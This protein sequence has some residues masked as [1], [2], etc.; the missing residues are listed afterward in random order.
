MAKSASRA[1]ALVPFSMSAP[2]PI[3]IRQ[4]KVQKAKKHRH[5]GGGGG[6][7]LMNK[8]RVGIIIGGGVL[9]FIEKQFAAQ[10]P[11][12]PVLGTTG[13]I[14]LAAYFLSDNGRNKLADEVCT[15]ALTVALWQLGN[16]GSI[17]GEEDPY[18]TGGY[19]AGA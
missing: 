16:T 4:T 5:H 2:K 7:G 19:V 15:A 11:K 6:S 14:G 10:I 12:I 13:T 8:R 17:V 9:G 3:I 18:M 1:R